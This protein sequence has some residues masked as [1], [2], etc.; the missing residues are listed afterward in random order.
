MGGG[1][2]AQRNRKHGSFK[3]NELLSFTTL[4]RRQ[5]AALYSN[6]QQAMSRKLDSVWG[7]ERLKLGS[8]CLPRYVWIQRA[9][10]TISNLL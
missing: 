10:K 6:I 4:I 1:A 7:T 9:V 3:W 8:F 5:N 2:A